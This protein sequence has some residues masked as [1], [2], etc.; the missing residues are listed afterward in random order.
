MHSCAGPPDNQN[1]Q[2]RCSEQRGNGANR[3]TRSRIYRPDGG[4]EEE[5]L[6]DYVRTKEQGSREQRA[7]RQYAPGVDTDD[8]SNDMWSNK[9]DETDGA[10]DSDRACSE[11][12]AH[13]NQTSTSAFDSQPQ[14]R[15]DFIPQ[16]EDVDETGTSECHR[17]RDSGPRP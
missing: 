3:E 11:E 1:Q 2:R 8:P 14:S 13:Q 17:Q 10:N 12:S 5:A 16:L 4:R 9:T 7:Q 15:R 6:G